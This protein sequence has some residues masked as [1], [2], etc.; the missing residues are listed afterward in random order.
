MK[1]FL[2]L[3]LAFSVLASALPMPIFADTAEELQ[4]KMVDAQAER[5]K[6][7]QEQKVLQ[8]QIDAAASQGKTLQS[9]V[10]QLQASMK[11]LDNDL[12][13]TQSNIS[14][15][16]LSIQKLS[17]T[18]EEKEHDIDVHRV[19][20]DDILKKLSERDT[21]SMLTDML[22]YDTISE[23]WQDT[24]TY[25][26]VEEKL[27]T[28]I[29]A[30]RNARTDLEKQ[31]AE[32]EG[33]KNELA[34]LQSQLSGQRG[35]IANTQSAQAKLLAETK[36]K[37]AAYQKLLADNIAREKEFEAALFQYESALK[38]V[39][40]PSSIPAANSTIFTWPVDNVKVTQRFGITSDSG[41]LYASGSH[42]GVDFGTP[43]GSAVHAVRQG[44]IKGQGN[45][46]SQPGCYSYGRWVLIEHDNGLSTIYGHL[47][48]SIVV[49]GQNVTAGQIIGYSGGA[50]GA[51]GS[52]YSTGPHVHLGTYAS[53]GVK[54]AQYSSSI[55]C[56]QVSI[57][58]ADPKSYLDALAYLPAI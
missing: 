25:K 46:D 8:A 53:E 58:L 37:E 24:E 43:V 27:V 6:L 3:I 20:L 13:I 11:K 38:S 7:L 19:A 39:V 55:G 10:N 31:K 18:M 50:P 2:I 23:V 36:S 21:E 33:K 48:S 28:E 54:I 34:G 14:N 35:T 5:V 16:N 4:Q 26:D 30:L 32:T 9:T 29:D 44:V 15:T 41:R 22:S 45:T 1:K 40:D 47:S 17:L 12:K 49:T 42:N 57:P 56:K 52:G 51:F